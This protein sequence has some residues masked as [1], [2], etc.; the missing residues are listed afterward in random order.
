MLTL[1]KVKATSY[2]IA[3]KNQAHCLDEHISINL[4]VMG[5][6]P[7]W[8]YLSSIAHHYRRVKAP[9]LPLKQVRVPFA[10]DDLT[11]VGLEVS[12]ERNMEKRT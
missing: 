5:S 12:A 4:A 9:P 7:G 8:P 3:F 6:K 11:T 1:L 10:E 2:F